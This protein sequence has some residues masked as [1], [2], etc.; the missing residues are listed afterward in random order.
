MCA[1]AEG[2]LSLPP[3]DNCR[4]HGLPCEVSDPK[5]TRAAAASPAIAHAAE[6]A[7]LLHSSHIPLGRGA[8][9]LNHLAAC[10]IGWL[11]RA[12]VLLLK[13]VLLLV[14]MPWLLVNA[15]LVQVLLLRRLRPLPH[16]SLSTWRDACIAIG[17]IV[18]QES[19]CM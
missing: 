19:C 8:C 9:A 17:M 7:A 2:P 5:H 14:V 13:N 15:L 6:F 18:Q 11:D 4:K 10:C 12:V 1:T 16:R 3:D